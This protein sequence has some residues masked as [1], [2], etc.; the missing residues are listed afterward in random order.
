MNHPRAK[1]DDVFS[2]H[3]AE[4]TILY[5][6]ANHKAHSLNKTV[7]LVWE[8]AD[9]QKSVDEL[10]AILHRELGL[11]NDP[12]VVLLSLEE[13]KTAGLLET[14]VEGTELTEAPSRRQVARRLALAGASAALVPFVASVLAPTPAMASSQPTITSAQYNADKNTVFGDIAN[15]PIQYAFSPTAQQDWNAGLTAGNQTNY[16]AAVTDFDGV[17]KALGLPPLT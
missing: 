15:H 9:G 6:K 13:L 14:T 7:S 11:P 5:D 1:R 8:S 2:E 16:T 17:L 4:E 3:L 12:G 10:A